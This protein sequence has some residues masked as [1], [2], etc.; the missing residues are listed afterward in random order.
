[1]FLATA[2]CVHLGSDN[3]AVG[4]LK[5]EQD[6][7]P[8]GVDVAQPRL[9][10]T[11]QAAGRGAA[12]TAYQVLAASSAAGLARDQGDLWDLSLIHI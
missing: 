1:M 3:L 2:G 7:D 10:W 6:V 9:G 5:C 4:G 12:Q 8:L 11:L